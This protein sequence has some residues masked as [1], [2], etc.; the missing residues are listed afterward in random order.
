M[1]FTLSADD[2]ADALTFSKGWEDLPLSDVL[3]RTW[4]KWQARAAIGTSFQ[5][6]GLVIIDHVVK[7]NLPLPLFTLDTGLLFEE[8]L[9]LQTRLETFWG[10][11]IE[12]LY[13]DLSV[14]EQAAQFGPKLWETDP[15]KCCTVRKVVPLQKKLRELDVW[16]TGVRR[17]QS[18][19]RQAAQIIELYPFD[20]DCDQYLFKLNPLANWPRARVQA[21]LKEHQIPTNPLLERGFRSIG[22]T[23]C[24]RPVSEGQNERAGRWTGFDKQECG[25]H[26]F[27]GL[28]MARKD[29][30]PAAQNP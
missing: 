12:R 10:R 28:A 4:D 26:T 7:L 18:E 23:P 3:S 29:T 21:Y 2:A 14:D 1:A 16:I 24:T 13:P 11:K 20:T 6:A 22:C 27:L 17:D 15:D 30:E 8:T 19:V 9:Q 5:G 25:I